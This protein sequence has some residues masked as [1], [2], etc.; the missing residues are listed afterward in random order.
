MLLEVRGE[1]AKAL[2]QA[3]AAKLIGAALDARV[4]LFVADPAPRR[5]RE[6]GLPRRSSGSS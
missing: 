3:R 6:A 4:T 2:E 1:V 5:D